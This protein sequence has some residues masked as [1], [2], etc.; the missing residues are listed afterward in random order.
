[1]LSTCYMPGSGSKVRGYQDGSHNAQSEVTDLPKVTKLLTVIHGRYKGLRALR[2][3]AAT[4]RLRGN[5]N[6]QPCF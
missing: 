6:L 4:I 5:R 3:T 1:M 2:L